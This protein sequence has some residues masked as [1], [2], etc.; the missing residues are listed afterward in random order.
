MTPPRPWPAVRIIAQEGSSRAHELR[1]VLA[2]NSIPYVFHAADSAE[3]RKRLRLA[4]QDGSVL[5]V[6]AIYT[7]EALADPST[8]Q[9]LIVLS[10]L[11]A[12]ED[13][14]VRFLHYHAVAGEHVRGLGIGYTFLRPSLF[15]QGCWRSPGR[16]PRR[17]GS[18]RRSAPRR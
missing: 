1:D 7:G 4:G 8:Q 14:P 13:S 17:A 5:P 12:D 2:R 15:F 3:C 11:A 16:C 10:Q 18:P 6:V 9:H